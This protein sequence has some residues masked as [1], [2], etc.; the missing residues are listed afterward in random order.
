MQ[1]TLRGDADG[2]GT[3]DT[4]TRITDSQ[5]QYHF[6]DLFPGTYIVSEAP[7]T[8]SAATTPVTVTVT[9]LGPDTASGT[10]TLVGV[11]QL[12]ATPDYLLSADFSNLLAG[13]STDITLTWSTGDGPPAGSP[14]NVNWTATI[15]AEGDTN[16]ANDVATARSLVVPNP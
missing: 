7:P 6:E 5:G 16:P 8:G 15:T 1:I 13:A 11:D 3:P 10:V 14:Q 12:P 4:L 2:N 9:N